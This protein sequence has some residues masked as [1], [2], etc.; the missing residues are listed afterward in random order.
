MAKTKARKQ[1]EKEYDKVYKRIQKY[2]ER[3]SDIGWKI[4]KRMI[5]P[6]KEKAKKAHYEKFKEIYIRDFRKKLKEIQSEEV[7]KFIKGKKAK[8][9][10]KEREKEYI[11][12]KRISKTFKKY[13][14]VRYKEIPQ[15][16]LP[17]SSQAPARGF[18]SELR[19]R[20]SGL[21]GGKW[22][23][24]SQGG[25]T[26]YTYEDKRNVLLSIIDDNLM[27]DGYLEYL[28]NKKEEIILE[29]DKWENQDSDQVKLEYSFIGLFNLLDHNK[30]YDI[31][32]VAEELSLMTEN[33]NP[34]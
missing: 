32:Q 11:E 25:R 19:S 33:Y 28:N 4:P 21:Y 18:L 15:P 34:T 2:I 24:S 8:R 23:K 29:I 3:F 7:G 13:K 22:V 10:G 14:D 27:Y 26:F 20:L 17:Y 30:L 31:N 12:Q 9:V 1:F 6:V 16:I 5:P